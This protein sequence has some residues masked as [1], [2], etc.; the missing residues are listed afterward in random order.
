M[1]TT[2]TVKTCGD[3][4]QVIN[5][6]QWKFGG[7]KLTIWF[8]IHFIQEPLTEA[9]TDVG[10]LWELVPESA[11]I[12]PGGCPTS[13]TSG[14]ISYAER[15]AASQEQRGRYSQRNEEDRRVGGRTLGR[16]RPA[17]PGVNC[18]ACGTLRHQKCRVS[19]KKEKIET[20]KECRNFKIKFFLSEDRR[21]LKRNRDLPGTSQIYE[22]FKKSLEQKKVYIHQGL[23]LAEEESTLFRFSI[24]RFKP[25]PDPVCPIAFQPESLLKSCIGKILSK[26]SVRRKQEAYKLIRSE[27][28]ISRTWAAQ[29]SG[30]TVS[31]ERILVEARREE[32]V[33]ITSNSQQPGPSGLQQS[34]PPGL[35][36]AVPLQ[37]Q[38]AEQRILR[39][40]RLLSD[41]G[42]RRRSPSPAPRRRSRLSLTEGCSQ[43][44]TPQA[45]ENAVGVRTR[46]AAASEREIERGPPPPPPSPAT[47]PERAPDTGG[48]QISEETQQVRRMTEKKGKKKN[49]TKGELEKTIEGLRVLNANLAGELGHYKERLDLEMFHTKRQDKLLIDLEKTFLASRDERIQPIEPIMTT[50]VSADIIF[51]KHALSKL[52]MQT[53]QLMLMVAGRN[54][55]DS[56]LMKDDLQISVDDVIQPPAGDPAGPPQ[57]PDQSL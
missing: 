50:D 55:N 16:G 12:C 30:R 34:A 26:V 29:I 24:N 39:S 41:P 17:G 8:L 4:I 43:G 2:L 47:S 35:Q 7:L 53:E 5:G 32:D 25:T 21:E 45:L 44:P 37:E 6:S 46:Q 13:T 23:T 19:D 11:D 51:L 28:A 22:I 31:A 52:S 42:T 40:G 18:H 49:Q 20:C 10:G 54:G 57:A 48:L 56:G 33:I 14:P 27:M 38:P 36:Q 1:T 3:E 9:V 15:I